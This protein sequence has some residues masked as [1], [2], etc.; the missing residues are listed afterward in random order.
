M[1][2]NKIIEKLARMVIQ[3]HINRANGID[4]GARRGVRRGGA[5]PPPK[6]K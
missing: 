2:T 6:P 4:M 1:N 5:S 3:N